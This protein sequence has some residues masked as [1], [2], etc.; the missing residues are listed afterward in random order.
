MSLNVLVISEDH[1]KD[2]FVLGPLIKQ[3]CSEVDKR[4]ARVKADWGPPLGGVAQ[5]LD[6]NRLAEIIDMNPQVHI[7]LLI[8]DRDGV[9]GRR[10]QLNRLEDLASQRLPK[11][12][13]F[14]GENA[15]QEIEVWALASQDLPSEWRWQEIRSE[16]HPKEV[17]FEPFAR[18]RGLTDEPGGGR[19]TLGIEAAKNYG[20]VRSRCP[21]DIG[22]LETRLKQRVGA[23]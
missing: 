20:R 7:F 6:W 22:R 3:M 17:Y 19:E 9:A 2:R 16:V 15:W 12:K 18:Q 21:E 11:E 8:V 14:L 23:I 4:H 13:V 10:E 5:A 1:R